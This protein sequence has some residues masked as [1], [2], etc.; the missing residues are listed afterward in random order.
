MARQAPDSYADSMNRLRAGERQRRR[1]L[2]YGVL[3]FCLSLFLALSFYS[4]SPEDPSLSSFGISLKVDNL[5]GYAG[6]FLSDLFFRLF[7]AF[8]WAFVLFGFLISWR[9]FRGFSLE[10]A[11]AA[12]LFPPSAAC[13]CLLNLYFPETLFFN[14]SVSLGG[15]LGGALLQGLKP[16]LHTIGATIFLWS[17]LALSFVFYGERYIS[18]VLSGL[19]SLYK[20]L[21]PKLLLKA[22][23]RAV[24]SAINRA[25]SL[26]RALVRIKPAAAI[27]R[28]KKRRKLRLRNLQNERELSAAAEEGARADPP[29]ALAS[30]S[31]AQDNEEEEGARVFPLQQKPAEEG[32]KEEEDLQHEAPLLPADSVFSLPPLDL[33]ESPPAS[34]QRIGRLEAESLSRKLLDKFAQFSIEGEVTAVK[35]GPAVTMFEFKPRDNVKISRI[36]EMAGDLSLALSSE[37]VRIIAPIPGRDVVGIETSHPQ[38]EKVYLKTLLQ[39]PDFA[40]V[41][42]PLILGKSADDKVLIEDLSRIPHLLIA[43]ATG[44]GKSVFVISFIAGLLFR[45]L[46]EDL[47]LIL[48]DPKQVDL[49]A[50]KGVPHLLAPPIVSAKRALAALHWTVAEMEKRYRSLACFGVRDLA[51]FN[52]SVLQLSAAERERHRIFNEEKPQKAYYYE[53]QPLIVIVIEEFGDLM[54]DPQFKRPVESAVVRLAQKARAAGVHLVLAMQSPRKDVVTGLIKTNIPGRISFKVSSGVD[55]RVILD[56]TG[57]ENLLSIGDMLFLRP[58]TS[59][60]SRFHGPFV[61]EKEVERVVSFWTDQGAPVYEEALRSS[62]KRRGLRPAAHSKETEGFLDKTSAG[63]GAGESDEEEA[64]DLFQESAAADPMYEDIAAF[65]QECDVVSAS[66]L[67][68]KFRIGYPRAARMIEVLYEEGLIGPPQGSKPRE[69]LNRR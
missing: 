53:K 47:R 61:S 62:S 3:F 26:L 23:L 50:F 13:C 15:A 22:V 55:S 17:V 43:G 9:S 8:S 39:E 38:R 54:A 68:R 58:G 14:G 59:K 21:K 64:G 44:S 65:V 57:A 46:P 34:P 56:E 51:S 25:A 4:H 27:R 18:F 63:I 42:L 24:F 41:P 31:F 36:K 5:C 12:L 66:F 40:A 45:R 2:F 29:P 35:T 32:A 49:S 20:I 28:W 1:N 33:L 48:I 7:G 16:L 69:V 6:A 30:A 60:P 52:R 19:W 67:Q 10:P 11:T 37:S